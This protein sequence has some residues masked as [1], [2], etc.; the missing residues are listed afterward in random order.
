MTPSCLFLAQPGNTRLFQ[1]APAG[2]WPGNK[3][4]QAWGG[5]D[6][7][8]SCYF[9][10]ATVGHNTDSCLAPQS[11]QELW[12]PDKV[13]P[14]GVSTT[15]R[16]SQ[17][18]SPLPSLPQYRQKVP[19]GLGRNGISAG[20]N[21]PAGSPS[22]PPPACL[23]TRLLPPAPHAPNSPHACLSLTAHANTWLRGHPL[24]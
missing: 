13:P 2:P 20:F 17:D 19:K 24:F 23:P 21:R 14:S 5:G 10:E 15:T 3:L 8:D 7:E 22:F 18:E 16:P 4:C 9:L 6:R 12:A 1:S 11:T